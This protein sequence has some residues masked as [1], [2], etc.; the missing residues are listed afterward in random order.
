MYRRV[1]DVKQ[2]KIEF[3]RKSAETST[4]VDVVIVIVLKLVQKCA[5][6]C[7]LVKSEGIVPKTQDLLLE[8][9]TNTA[10]TVQTVQ[11]VQKTVHSAQQNQHFKKG[12][13][14]SLYLAVHTPYF[15]IFFIFSSIFR[16]IGSKFGNWSLLVICKILIQVKGHP[17]SAILVWQPS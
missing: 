7:N 11:T 6:Q 1:C 4:W 2:C 15:H 3:R 16:P 12:K 14:I 5:K 17:E 9:W 8:N 13:Q 10:K